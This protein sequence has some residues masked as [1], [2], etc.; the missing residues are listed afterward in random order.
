MTSEEALSK[1]ISERIKLNINL[2][3]RDEISSKDA[4]MEP[5]ADKGTS[6][7]TWI[8]LQDTG[9][10]KRPTNLEKHG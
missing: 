3:H 6:K 4:L 7:Q 2:L 8:D 9:Q 1:Q 10:R 5:H